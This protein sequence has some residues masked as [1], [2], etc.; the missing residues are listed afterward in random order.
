[1]KPAPKHVCM[2][3]VLC[4][5]ELATLKQ[6]APIAKLRVVLFDNGHRGFDLEGMTLTDQDWLRFDPQDSTRIADA[7]TCDI[8]EKTAQQLAKDQKKQ[9]KPEERK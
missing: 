8:D 9:E 7:L 3:C 1:M 4:E 2:V 6:E 5:I